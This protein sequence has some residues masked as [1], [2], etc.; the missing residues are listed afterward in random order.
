M[1]NLS[2]TARTITAHTGLNAT[3]SL[4]LYPAAGG[5]AKSNASGQISMTIPAQGVV[6]V[7]AG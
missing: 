7:R 2:A 5:M 4:A 3:T 1:I 6:T